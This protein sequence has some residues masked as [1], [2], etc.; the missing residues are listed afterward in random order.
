MLLPLALAVSQVA[1]PPVEAPVR[2]EIGRD[3]VTDQ[4][5][6]SAVVWSAG[7]NRL[8]IHCD[9]ARHD[10]I[11]V[12]LSSGRFTLAGGAPFAGSQPI[13]HRFDDQ[14]PERD[15][16]KVEGPR[17]ELARPG[18]VASFLRWFGASERL[19]LRA[20][21]IEGRQVDYRFELGR[22]QGAVD[23]LIAACGEPRRRYPLIDWLLTNPGWPFD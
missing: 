16:W 1:Y 17:A 5:R 11:R 3:P 13:T 23:Q 7:G 22:P 2:V 15:W 9:P 8:R 21:D 12:T 18:S 20:R 10:G 14:T 19:V 4:P 6:A